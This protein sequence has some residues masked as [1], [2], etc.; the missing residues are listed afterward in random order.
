MLISQKRFLNEAANA[1]VNIRKYV[2]SQV[3]I[4]CGF[5]VIEKLM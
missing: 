3:S 2:K 5:T 4:V 1:S